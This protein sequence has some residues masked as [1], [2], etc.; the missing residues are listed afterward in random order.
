MG[1]G[2]ETGSPLAIVELLVDSEVKN[3]SFPNFF[4]NIYSK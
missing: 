1:S 3:S 2:D 4:V